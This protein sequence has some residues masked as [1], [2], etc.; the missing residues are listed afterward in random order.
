MPEVIPSDLSDKIVTTS[1]KWTTSFELFTVFTSA[2]FNPANP[3]PMLKRFGKI[4][5]KWIAEKKLGRYLLYALGEIVL[6]VIGILIA[7]GISNWNEAQKD[8]RAER[9]FLVSF[10]NDLQTDVQT[11][12]DKMRSNAER[13]NHTDSII[14]VLSERDQLSE[15]ERLAFSRWNM[16]L[17][18]E[19]YFIPEK[20]T[21]SQFE[22][23]DN[24]HLIAEALKDKLFSY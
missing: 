8:A 18:F 22:A 9:A 2:C 11:L 20:S 1:A 15:A 14:S 5:E 13:I 21:I 3:Q 23:S 7:L 17:A 10:R 12:S 4:R 19:S 16:S 6:I 24:G